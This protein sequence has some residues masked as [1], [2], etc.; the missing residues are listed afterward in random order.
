LSS[1]P[2]AVSASA[3]TAS[4]RNLLPIGR[5]VTPSAVSSW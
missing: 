5:S 4:R 3:A 2:Q 1:P